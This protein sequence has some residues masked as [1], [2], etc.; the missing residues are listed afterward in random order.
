MAALLEAYVQAG[1]GLP[2]WA[3]RAKIERAETL[4]MDYGFLSCT[5]LDQTRP[6]K[7]PQH[8][9][10]RVNTMMEGW[11]KNPKASR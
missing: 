7:L 10:N 5:L 9:L 1:Q 8:L 6:L 3:D 4:F 11:R 2:A